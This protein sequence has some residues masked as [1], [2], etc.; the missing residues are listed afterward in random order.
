MGTNALP[1]LLHKLSRSDTRLHKPI[2]ILG[3][4]LTGRVPLESLD[5]ERQQA[6]TA[7]LVLSPLPPESLRQLAVMTNS[8]NP[9]IAVQAL[10]VLAR[11]KFANNGA[12]PPQS[13]PVAL[14]QEQRMTQHTHW[15]PPWASVYMSG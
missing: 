11:N 13:L 10:G 8:A 5:A 12:S 15:T 2:Q 14:T 3:Y 7:L 9:K 4:K 1:F 6:T